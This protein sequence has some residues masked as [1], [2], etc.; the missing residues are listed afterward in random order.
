MHNRTIGSVEILKN[1]TSRRTFLS[2]Q[3]FENFQNSEIFVQKTENE[4][5]AKKEG[6]CNSE[7]FECVSE[8]FQVILKYSK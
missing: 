1:S 8:I 2:L 4:K 5:L 3:L 6:V 7:I